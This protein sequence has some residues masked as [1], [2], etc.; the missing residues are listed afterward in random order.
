MGLKDTEKGVV[1]VELFRITDETGYWAS[2]PDEF[3]QVE[4][5]SL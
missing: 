1:D 3:P 2:E 4:I 5:T